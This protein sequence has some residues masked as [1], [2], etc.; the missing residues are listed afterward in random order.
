MWRRL[1]AGEL[2]ELE[3]RGIANSQEFWEAFEMLVLAEVPNAFKEVLQAVL[4]GE[5]KEETENT[6]P[7]CGRPFRTTEILLRHAQIC[8][9]L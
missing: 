9:T 3:K 2:A 1:S 5:V 8:G 6:C 4:G 7:I